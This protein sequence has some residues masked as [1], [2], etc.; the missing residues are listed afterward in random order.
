MSLPLLLLLLPE[1]ALNCASMS[2]NFIATFSIITTSSRYLATVQGSIVTVDVVEMS[3]FWNVSSTR[4]THITCTVA[5][6][7]TCCCCQFIKQSHHHTMY[8]QT[9]LPTSTAHNRESCTP[10]PTSILSMYSPEEFVVP[11]YLGTEHMS[12]EYVLPAYCA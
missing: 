8:R 12:I 5:G 6:D 7:S 4:R 9:R 1:D 3:R 2:N 10:Y 11:A